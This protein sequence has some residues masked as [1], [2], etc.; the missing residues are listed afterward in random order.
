MIEEGV[1]ENSILVTQQAVGRN[2]RGEPTAKVV[3]ADGK[4]E[5]CVLTVRRSV[6]NAWL[7]DEG[8][9]AGDRVVVEGG[10]NVRAGQEVTAESVA[11]DDA[12][13]EIREA[14]LKG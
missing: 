4:V 5:E 1:A 7:V 10:E 8:L 6:G 12:K 13:G 14:A 2:A 9:K 3:T 11:I